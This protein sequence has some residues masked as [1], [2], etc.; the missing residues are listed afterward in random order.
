M[1][2]V[3]TCPICKTEKCLVL[4]PHSDDAEIGCGGIISRF[5]REGKEVH[6]AIFGLAYKATTAEIY[7]AVN[8]LGVSKE[9][10]IYQPFTS[11]EFG[12][13]RQEILELMLFIKKEINPDLVFLPVSEDIHQDHQ[14]IH[15]EGLR[16]FKDRSILGYEY[17]WNNFTIGV[18]YFFRLQDEDIKRKVKAIKEYKSQR[19]KDYMREDFIKSWAKL[20]GIQIK[21]KYAEAFEAIRIIK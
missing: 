19:D 20:R 7:K 12:K 6:I 8:R 4:A 10:V 11:R 21:E 14:T 2:K 5:L 9:N 18:N 3:P 1:N 16:A 17:P 15:Q 13:D